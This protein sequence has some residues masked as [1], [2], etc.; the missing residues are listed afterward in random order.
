M[1]LHPIFV[2]FPIA[3]LT[4][5]AIFEILPVNRW[6]GKLPWVAIKT[7]LVVCGELGAVTALLTGDNA[8]H[9]IKDQAIRQIV[10]VHSNFAAATAIIFG[11]LAVARLI[12]WIRTEHPQLLAK[13]YTTILRSID[14]VINFIL[15]TPIRTF[16]A[17]AGLATVTITGGLGG[18]IVYGPDIDPVVKFI[19]G[20]FF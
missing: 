20:L 19:Y 17:L 15:S 14:L 10:E 12:N 18:A 11:V 8:E 9:A 2:H 1:D 5:Y 13:N 6:Y 3:L 4:V 7:I 16:L